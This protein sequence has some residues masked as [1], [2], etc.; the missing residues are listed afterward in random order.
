VITAVHALAYA[1]DPGAARAFF[2]DVLGWESIDAHD[3]WLIFKSGPSELAVHPAGEGP[4]HHEVSL[5]CDDIEETVADLVAKGAAFEGGIE[6]RRFG[7]CIEMK[8]PGG[9]TM[10]LYEPTH[11][12]AFD[13]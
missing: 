9:A 2:R 8:V 10:L 12:T 6:D 5:M 13:L 11:P 4:M 7:R 3:G 1:D